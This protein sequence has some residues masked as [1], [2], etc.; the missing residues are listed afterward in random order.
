MP[1]VTRMVVIEI[2]P[3]C[4]DRGFELAHK[5]DDVHYKNHWLIGILKYIPT[6]IFI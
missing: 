5:L 1:A 4:S 6:I 3:Y 2:V